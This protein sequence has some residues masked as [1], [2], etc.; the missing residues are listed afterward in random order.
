MVEPPAKTSRAFVGPEFGTPLAEPLAAR[1]RAWM[2]NL[3]SRWIG[4]A[5][6]RR[7]AC[8]SACCSTAAGSA[9]G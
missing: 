9:Q 3:T 1:F 6:S 8:C 5:T 7:T 4:S 2:R